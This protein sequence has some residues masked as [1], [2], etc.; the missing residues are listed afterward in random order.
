MSKPIDPDGSAYDVMAIYGTLMLEVQ[1]FELGVASLS[2]IAEIDPSQTSNASV[3]RQIMVAYKKSRHRFHRGSLSASR[4][5]L[6]GKID[7]Q[8]FAEI[9][10]LL[11]HRNRL[12]HRFLV[13][14]I[15]GSSQEARFKTGTA[16]EVFEYARSFKETGARVQDATRR[17][18]EKLPGPPNE[19]ASALEAFARS[20]V[21]EGDVFSHGLREN[22]W[23]VRDAATR[24]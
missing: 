7:S 9:E 4:D 11:P 8:L 15:A 20:V 5:R 1:S 21:F 19:I 18:A 6:K 17:Y 23:V 14:R 22:P 13:D 16:L 10:R 2:L 24:P 3:Q 12:A